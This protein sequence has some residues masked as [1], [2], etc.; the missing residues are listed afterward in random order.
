MYNIRFLRFL[1]FLKWKP[2]L[3]TLMLHVRHKTT[4]IFENLDFSF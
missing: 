4:I 3:T 2:L 1:I